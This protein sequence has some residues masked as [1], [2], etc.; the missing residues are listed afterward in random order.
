M[1]T[2]ETSTRDYRPTYRLSSGVSKREEATAWPS[3]PN[4]ISDFSRIFFSRFAMFIWEC[5]FMKHKHNSSI[6]HILLY[7]RKK[8]RFLHATSRS[9]STKLAEIKTFMRGI[10]RS[11]DSYL[12]LGEGQSRRCHGTKRNMRALVNTLLHNTKF[13]IRHWSYRTVITLVRALKL[14]VR[15]CLRNQCTI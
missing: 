6:H 3:L 8:Y 5:W 2:T 11:S 10:H 15:T 9:S 1:S 4:G 14:V 12:D 13:W 7:Q